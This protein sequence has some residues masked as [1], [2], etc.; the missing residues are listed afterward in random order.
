MKNLVCRN[1]A[2]RFSAFVYAG[3]YES[4]RPPANSAGKDVPAK[5]PSFQDKLKRAE[6]DMET[7]ISAEK[8]DLESKFEKGGA[9]AVASTAKKA[10]EEKRKAL[11]TR[12]N[13]L[14]LPSGPSSENAVARIETAKAINKKASEASKEI[15]K[16][17]K[18]FKAKKEYA[19]IDSHL[20]LK[21]RSRYERNLKP[22]LDGLPTWKDFSVDVST[23]QEMNRVE[24]NFSLLQ[25]MVSTGDG[26]LKELSTNVPKLKKLKGIDP[27]L[28]KKLD[29]HIPVLERAEKAVTQG[30][31]LARETYNTKLAELQGNMKASKE[32]AGKKA[33]EYRNAS[34]R[35]QMEMDAGKIKADERIEAYNKFKEQQKFAQTLGQY[36]QKIKGRKPLT[37]GASDKGEESTN[38]S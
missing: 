7:T 21:V 23:Q 33:V 35:A 27:D 18:V 28:D 8:K 4:F 9:D 30:T 37:G 31:K 3:S 2:S 29:Q 10:I 5:E 6:S 36:E 24:T 22:K 19:E 25:D 32:A 17:A 13:G 14:K 11:E 1:R 26:I 34:G 16:A 12:V 38:V 20:E 15:D